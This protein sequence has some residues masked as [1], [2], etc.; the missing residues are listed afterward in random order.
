MATNIFIETGYPRCY[1]PVLNEQKTE[2]RQRLK[3]F[4][5]MSAY[6]F[7]NLLKVVAALVKLQDTK[8]RTA[9]SPSWQLAVTL[10]LLAA[11]DSFGSLH[12]PTQDFKVENQSADC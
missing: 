6:D 12:V 2:D 7:E 5:R 4:V 10:R 9:V 3:N 11:S 8:F 1:Q